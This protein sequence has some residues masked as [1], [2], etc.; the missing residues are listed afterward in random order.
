MT[1]ETVLLLCTI[2][3]PEARLLPWIRRLAAPGDPLATRWERVRGNYAHALVAAS[4][5]TD[6]RSRAGL[7]AAGWEVIDGADE[8]SDRGLRALVRR[9]LTRPE[10]RIHYC[11]L[12]RLVH[13]LATFPEELAALPAVWHRADLVMLARSPRAFATHPPCQTLTEGP[14][15]RLIAARIGVP[16]ADAFS[17]SYL[18]SRRAAR[19]VSE[20]PGPADLRFYAEG[21]LAPFRAGCTIARHE[22]E[23]LE[24]ETPDQYAAEIARLGYAAWLEQFQSALQWR[25]RVEMA[26]L[27]IEAVLT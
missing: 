23:G 25:R 14:I 26:S 1:G 11:D 10:E 17:G 27:W 2:H 9:G 5:A 8:G 3:D 21:V 20:A 22:V 13:W 18:W 7:A 15:N 6:P 24:W 12:D 16:G 4:A 19:A